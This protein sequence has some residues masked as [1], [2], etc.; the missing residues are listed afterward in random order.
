[1]DGFIAF[2]KPALLPALPHTLLSRGGRI[3]WGVGGWGGVV[4]GR[5]MGGGGGGRLRILWSETQNLLL[6]ESW[7]EGVSLYESSGGMFSDRA[8]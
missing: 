1:M 6:P 3:R 5:A 7:Q 4:A 8:T 2:T